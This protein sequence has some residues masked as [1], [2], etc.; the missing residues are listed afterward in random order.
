MII[1]LGLINV[2]FVDVK[3]IMFGVGIVLMGIGLV[4]GEGWLFKVVEIVINL[5]LLEVLMEGV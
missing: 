3:G 2:D 4:W 5:L 1:I